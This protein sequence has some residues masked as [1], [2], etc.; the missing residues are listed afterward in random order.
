[1][2]AS[3]SQHPSRQV[4]LV[5]SRLV[6]AGRRQASDTAAAWRRDDAIDFP[7]M[8]VNCHRLSKRRK[9]P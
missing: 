1:M 3:L 9:T 4:F 2:R 7:K 5:W 6:F 8:G